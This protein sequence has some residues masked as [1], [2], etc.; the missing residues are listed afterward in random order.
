MGEPITGG[1]P[2]GGQPHMGTPVNMGFG[3]PPLSG[4]QLGVSL[5]SQWHSNQPGLMDQQAQELQVRHSI[6][7]FCSSQR[8]NRNGSFK[9]K[10]FN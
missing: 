5:Y 10:T 7:P 6:S 8:L 1:V 4:P 3:Q 9:C 2:Q